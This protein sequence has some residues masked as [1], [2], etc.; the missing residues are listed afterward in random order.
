MQFQTFQD[1]CTPVMEAIVEVHAYIMFFLAAHV[2][3]VALQVRSGGSS[4]TG[5]N[6]TGSEGG[7]SGK[8]PEPEFVPWYYRREVI[9]A[10]V[11]GTA[12][13]G[14]VLWMWSRGDFK[15]WD[16]GVPLQNLF[17][18]LTNWSGHRA[19]ELVTEIVEPVTVQ[20][21]LEQAGLTHYTADDFA[22]IIEETIHFTNQALKNEVAPDVTESI[23]K[24]VASGA[25]AEDAKEVLEQGMRSLIRKT[26]RRICCEVAKTV[27]GMDS[28]SDDSGADGSDGE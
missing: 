3:L 9:V 7:G 15:G 10:I 6:G 24:L 8:P 19:I 25:S 22:E 12:V 28:G 16:W 5:G 11:A 21:W 20:T 18:N 27:I 1:P 14:V 17:G 13:L 2:T 26:A 4:S 23:F